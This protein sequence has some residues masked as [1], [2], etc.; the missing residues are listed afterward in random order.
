[1]KFNLI[2]ILGPTAVGKTKFAV[3]LANLFNGEIISADSR[4]VYKQMDLG[5][6]KD[7]NDYLIGKRKIP[8]HLIDIIEPKEEYN[9]FKFKYDFYK[10]YNDITKRGKLPFLVG[11]TGLYIHSILKNY[12]LIKSNSDK[13]LLEKYNKF[14]LE[15]LQ[16]KL[17]KVNPNLHN[18]TDMLIKERVIQALIIAESKKTNNEINPEI[19]SLNIGITADR[20]II[21]K[22]ITT[23]LKNRLKE[24]MIEEV[25]SLISNGVPLNRLKLFGLEY[26]FISMYLNKEINYND[27][28][29]KLNSAIHKFAKRQMTWFR[30]MKK[31]D[32]KIIWLESDKIDYAVEL[33]KKELGV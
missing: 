19:N 8:Y 32:V 14:S 2:T 3:K 4:Q 5:T 7:Y 31:E 9:L 17:L 10:A 33:I 16:N 23:R 22:R 15:E 29:Q 28:F 21:R 1:M 30:K 11:G 13:S 6:G 18:T 27:M 12:E 25:E 20:A 24:G 26:K